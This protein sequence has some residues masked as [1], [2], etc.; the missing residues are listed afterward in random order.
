MGKFT[1]G[2][3]EYDKLYGCIHHEGLL[4]AE[5]SGAG[6]SNYCRAEGKANAC[7]IAAAP[8][9]YELLMDYN[10]DPAEQ[11]AWLISRHNLLARID[12]KDASDE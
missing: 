4:V 3:W 7:L 5:V 1:P 12:G 10:A 6:G 2:R 11:I 8:E 9:M